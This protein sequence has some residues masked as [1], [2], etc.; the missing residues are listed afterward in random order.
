MCTT[1]E[2]H[3]QPCG[4]RGACLAAVH[5]DGVRVVACGDNDH[6][7]LGAGDASAAADAGTA[8]PP[9]KRVLRPVPV[10]LQVRLVVLHVGRGR[11]AVLACHSA[12]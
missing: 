1:G 11:G 3:A 8:E 6:G 12:T 9:A 2:T 4:I 5:A 10:K 7:Q